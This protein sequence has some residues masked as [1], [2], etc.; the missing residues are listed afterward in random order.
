[1]V[2]QQVKETIDLEKDLQS[3]KL[4]SVPPPVLARAKRDGFSDAYL[5]RMWGADA[6]AVRAGARNSVSAPCSTGWIPAPRSSRALRPTCTPA[7]NPS[8]RRAFG[9]KKVMILGQRPEPYRPGHRVRL[10]AAATLLRSPG[11]RLRVDHGQ[12]QPETVSTDYDTS[13][14]LYFERAHF[15]GSAEYLDTEKPDG[16]IRAVWR[17]DAAPPWR[18]R[19]S[20]RA[21]HHRTDPAKYRPGRGPQAVRQTPGRSGDPLPGQRR[22]HQRREA[23]E[24]A[25]HR[26]PRARA[27]E[28]RAGRPRHVI[29]YEEEDRSP[30]YARGGSVS[31]ASARAHRSFSGRRDGNRRGRAVGFRRCADRWHYG[32]HR[33]GGHP[34]GDSSCVLPAT[35]VGEKERAHNRELHRP[36]GARAASRRSDDVQYAIKDG[37]VYVLEVNP[38]ASRTVPYVSKGHRVPLP[39]RRGPDARQE[40]Q[41]FAR[42]DRGAGLRLPSV[43]QFFVKSPCSRS[44]S[45]GVD[46]ALVPRCVR[47][48]RLMGVG[49]NFGEA[50]A[51]SAV[52]RRH[53]LRRRAS[54]SSA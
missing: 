52:E 4:E 27:A 50:F 1:V 12:L 8:A 24:V 41:E 47:R 11:I 42:P 9:R 35:S 13:D 53:P 23:C 25:A 17:P 10:L 21:V 14:R 7:T 44:T 43:T 20:A 39:S 5:A 3:E 30:L 33:G 54:S 36:A 51:Q 22:R 16:V 31:R 37:T 38:R 28:L 6:L 26:I 29:A 48:A 45:S 15:G 34:L 46:P 40:A 32:A 2:P 18:S 49:V 19:L